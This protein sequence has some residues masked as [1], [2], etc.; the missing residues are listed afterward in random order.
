MNQ[1]FTRVLWLTLWWANAVCAAAPPCVE[2]VERAQHTLSEIF[3]KW[4][5]H[6]SGDPLDAAVQSLTL[7]LATRAD[8]A[9]RRHWRV[10]VIRDSKTNAFSIG[11]GHIFVTEG[12]LRFVASEAE[13]MTLL[14]HEF[15][16]HIAQHFC[17]PPPRG[18]L[19]RMFGPDEDSTRHRVGSLT[20]LIDPAKEQQAD[21]MAVSILEHAGYDPRAALSLAT[22]MTAEGVVSDFQHGGRIAALRD[23]LAE[24]RAPI[25]APEPSGLFLQM[26][27]ALGRAP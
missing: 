5:L 13:L 23:L 15:A 9:E 2:E 1:R 24:R 3:S 10:H 27:N 17:T 12:M 8:I 6:A 14:A 21:R 7:R 18:I 19:H 16:H 26:K 22:R 20:A 4:P 11:D 25:A